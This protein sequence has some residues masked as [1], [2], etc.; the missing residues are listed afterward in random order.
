MLGGTTMQTI[1]LMWVT[2][3]TDWNNEV[4]DNLLYF[5]FHMR[6]LMAAINGRVVVTFLMKNFVVCRWKKQPRG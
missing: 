6:S 5:Y 1:I 3:R 2:F 4:K